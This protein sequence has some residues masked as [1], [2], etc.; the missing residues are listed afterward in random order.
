MKISD[1]LTTK[2][3]EQLDTVREQMPDSSKNM[4]PKI[5]IK[6]HKCAKELINTFEKGFIKLIISNTGFITK[7][8]CNERTFKF[9]VEHT[10]AMVVYDKRRAR[11][12]SN[13]IVKEYES[14]LKNK[15][16]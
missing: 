16:P 4:S 15:K 13:F 14:Y 8:I 3:T 7:I 10:G 5:E 1:L 9:R 2:C 11:L 6:Y 12:L